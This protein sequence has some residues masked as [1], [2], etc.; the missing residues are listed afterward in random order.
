MYLLGGWSGAGEVVSYE[1]DNKPNPVSHLE[2]QPFLPQNMLMKNNP[3][4]A[5]HETALGDTT[6]TVEHAYT[7]NSSSQ[8][9]VRTTKVTTKNGQG[10]G[11]SVAGFRYDS[12]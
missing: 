4:K 12:Y 6:K 5:V 2:G 10:S 8:P 9:L 11:T 7:Y 3:V 1:Y